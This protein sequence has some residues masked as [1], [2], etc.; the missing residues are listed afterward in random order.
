[1]HSS[2]IYIYLCI[3]LGFGG[4]WFFENLNQREKVKTKMDSG[5]QSCCK[6]TNDQSSISEWG[7]SGEFHLPHCTIFETHGSLPDPYSD[8]LSFKYPG[9]C[10][11]AIYASYSSSSRRPALYAHVKVLL[12]LCECS[13]I[14]KLS[15]SHH[16]TYYGQSN[17]PLAHMCV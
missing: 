5:F 11:K 9:E 16:L 1:M 10:P 2:I 12:S 7:V 4:F 14:S 15:L 8:L 17:Q 3:G 6:Q 13:K